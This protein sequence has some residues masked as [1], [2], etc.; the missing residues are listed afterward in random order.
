ESKARK[1]DPEAEDLFLRGRFLSRRGW[2]DVA[3][4]AVE[5]LSKAHERAPDDARIMGTYALTLARVYGMDFFG[6]EVADRARALASKAADLDPTQAEAKTALALLHL[7]NQEVDA[8]V[9]FFQQAL[10]VGPN[11]VEALDWF[12]RVLGEV[13]RID[14]AF[15]LLK[16]A[17]AIDPESVQARQ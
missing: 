15:A 4:E 16:K 3:R 9:R 6:R 8:A 2:Q 1:A 10:G 14:D 7:Q 11:S 5:L 17:G 13:G 12:G